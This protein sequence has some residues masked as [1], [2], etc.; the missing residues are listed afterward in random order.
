MQP[1]MWHYEGSVDASGKILTLEADGPSMLKPGTTAK[2]R[3]VTEFKSKDERVYSS[4]IQN[5][6]GE[7]VKMASGVAKRKK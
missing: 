4:Y 7:R 5:Q 1:H 3:D 2:Y 6:K